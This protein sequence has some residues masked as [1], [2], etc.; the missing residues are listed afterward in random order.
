MSNAVIETLF[1]E[2]KTYFDTHRFPGFSLALGRES[3]IFHTAADGYARPDRGKRMTEATLLRLG[4]LSKIFTTAAILRLK[5][6]G[7]LSLGDCL[8][9][10]YPHC[11]DAPN[12][13]ADKRVFQIT[14][15]Q[16]LN[17]TSGLPSDTGRMPY[18]VNDDTLNFYLRP[19]NMTSRAICA[20]LYNC[21][22]LYE[23][24]SDQT[25]ST[26]G[27]SVIGRVI[28]QVSGMP[29][30]AFL[31]QEVLDH[32][33]IDRVIM[34]SSE[35]DSRDANEAD[36]YNISD[37]EGGTPVKET[38]FNFGPSRF[39]E[40]RDAAGGL[41]TSATGLVTAVMQLYEASG[42]NIFDVGIRQD[43]LQRP[44]DLIEPRPETYVGLGWWIRRPP[45]FEEQRRD[46]PLF[47][48]KL[49]HSGRTSGAVGFL[50]RGEN[51]VW[52]GLQS[53]CGVSDKDWGTLQKQIYD[54]VSWRV[55]S[56]N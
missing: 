47:Q 48:T 6:Q 27:Y 56:L 24:G 20:Y 51:G 32:L 30:Y 3:A 17:H 37:L 16:L 28:E 42:A 34:A 45:G 10:F 53:N 44:D 49:H 1:S 33:R 5:Q 9:T 29:Y 14:L 12:G 13:P 22:L 50:F 54:I 31:K 8:G 41:V 26:I 25:Y 43:L 52:A 11:E 21:H 19:A 15:K 55:R 38:S 46:D 23:P 35:E 18:M 39:I 7:Q 36:Y 40:C 4:S 2:L